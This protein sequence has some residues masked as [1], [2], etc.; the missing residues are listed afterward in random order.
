MQL[1]APYVI[2]TTCS[3]LGGQLADYAIRN[4]VDKTCKYTWLSSSHTFM[5][6]CVQMYDGL[7]RL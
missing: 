7:Q 1:M 2:M 4:G 3:M 5:T 6:W